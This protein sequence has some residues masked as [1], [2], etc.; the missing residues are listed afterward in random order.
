VALKDPDSDGWLVW[1][2]A[3][4]T[5]ANIMLIGVITAS[6]FRRMARQF[7][8]RT[9]FSGAACALISG[10]GKG[11]RPNKDLM[12]T[13][14]LM[15]HIVS[16]TPV[17]THAF[18]NLTYQTLFHVGTPDGKA[19]RIEDGH[20]TN[21]EDDSPGVDGYSARALAGTEEGCIA[22]VTN[23]SQMPPAFYNTKVSSR[24][25]SRQSVHRYSR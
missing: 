24:S 25:S 5:D 23:P 21:V 16:L 15:S 7:A 3:S 2:L 17:E 14:A 12:L 9:P 13:G 8:P 22:T 10:D 20:I 4:T 1:A 11:R 18:A 6:P 19:W